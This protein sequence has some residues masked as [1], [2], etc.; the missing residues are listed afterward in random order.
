METAL[1]VTALAI[2]SCSLAV[3]DTICTTTEQAVQDVSYLDVRDNL[4]PLQT[5]STKLLATG[6]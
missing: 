3:L 2:A 4:T 5:T 1:T 6:Q